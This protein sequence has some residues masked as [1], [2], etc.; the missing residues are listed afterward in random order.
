MSRQRQGWASSEWESNAPVPFGA[1]PRKG[2]VL[3]I[4]CTGGP[5]AR[6]SGVVRAQGAKVVLNCKM[7]DTVSL[8]A[9]TAFTAVPAG[10]GGSWR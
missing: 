5:V 9:P 4:K 6:E 1:A 8:A 7:L 2:K 3:L 10:Y